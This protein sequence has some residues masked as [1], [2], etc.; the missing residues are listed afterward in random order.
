[1]RRRKCKQME[2]VYFGKKKTAVVNG[3]VHTAL[4][5]SNIKGIECKFARA[6]PVFIGL[7]TRTFISVETVRHHVINC[8]S[9][10][11]VLRDQSIDLI[12]GDFW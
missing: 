11:C 7:Q 8:M 3:S 4:H 10:N 1:M 2:I 12:V 6:R 9:I 5:T